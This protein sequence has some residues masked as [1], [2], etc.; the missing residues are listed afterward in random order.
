MRHRLWGVTS[1]SDTTQ[2]QGLLTRCV[3][4]PFSRAERSGADCCLDYQDDHALNPELRRGD[5]NSRW[6]DDPAARPDNQPIGGW[7]VG[8]RLD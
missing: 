8:V 4:P 2:R 7:P 1:N 6:R 3:W 5:R